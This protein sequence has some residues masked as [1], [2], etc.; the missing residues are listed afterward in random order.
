MNPVLQRRVYQMGTIEQAKKIAKIG[1]MLP[2]ETE[3]FLLLHSGKKEKYIMD[4]LGMTE[5][6]YANVES[7]VSAKF[8]VAMFYCICFTI[9]HIQDEEF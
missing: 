5:K 6:T 7:A 3:T 8:T 1:G 2:E 9:D 4:A